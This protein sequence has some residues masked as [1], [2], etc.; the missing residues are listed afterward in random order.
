MPSINEDN[1]HAAYVYQGNALTNPAIATDATNVQTRDRDEEMRCK[2]ARL[3][4]KM[5]YLCSIEFGFS[6]KIY[7][8]M[9]TQEQ[10]VLPH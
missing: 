2:M 4:I 9:R 10:N 7:P 1:E 8:N 5:C 6:P 3:G